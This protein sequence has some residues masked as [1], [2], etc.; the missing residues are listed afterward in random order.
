MTNEESTV[1]DKPLSRNSLTPKLLA[2]VYGFANEEVE[3]SI[4][5]VVRDVLKERQ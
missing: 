4:D 5:E 2:D 1:K 3:D